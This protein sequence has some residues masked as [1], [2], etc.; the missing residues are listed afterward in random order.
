LSLENIY[1]RQQSA[2]SFVR[3]I[4]YD[5]HALAKLARLL[6]DYYSS[7]QRPLINIL[8]IGTGP[9]SLILP[10]AESFLEEGGP[11]FRLDCL[12]VSPHMAH[13]FEAALAASRVPPGKVRY[14][15]HD[16]ERGLGELYS[17]HGYDLI[18]A[19]FVLH[20]IR[21][22]RQLLDEATRCL[23]EGGLLVQ[24]EI[25]G[26]FRNLDGHF[27]IKSPILFEQFWR[28]YFTERAKYSAWSPVISVSDLSVAF[29]YLRNRKRLKLF[30]ED[31]L[32]WDTSVEWGDFCNWIAD[33]PL[34]SLG[35]G[36]TTEARRELA[37]RMHG[38]LK[39][40][41]VKLSSGISLR[42]GIKVTCLTNGEK[43]RE[44]Y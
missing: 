31:F 21:N 17:P 16:A 3:A 10:V 25:V 5:A 7:N 22:W 1:L 37:R 44:T 26:D 20:Y 33:A 6:A 2:S 43:K 14:L 15:L 34:S 24:T 35:A 29:A 19:T 28:Q 36:L 30:R 11:D 8:D 27:D 39:G 42:W 32:L 40:R 38:W 41:R 13:L 23:T 12:D 18:F 9:G 4:N